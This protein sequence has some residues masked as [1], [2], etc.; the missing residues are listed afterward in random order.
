MNLLTKF[1]LLYRSSGNRTCALNVYIP[2]FLLPLLLYFATRSFPIAIFIVFFIIPAFLSH[3]KLFYAF[4]LTETNFFFN[5]SIISLLYI[6][7]CFEFLVVPLMIISPS[8]SIIFYVLFTS[9]VLFVQKIKKNAPRSAS[10]V[11][12]TYCKNNKEYEKVYSPKQEATPLYLET[13][14]DEIA[15]CNFCYTTA[16]QRNV[17]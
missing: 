9:I 14:Q 7:M 11:N 2:L 1:R 4:G 6:F 13:T 3:M 15:V 12:C 5:W 10:R 17:W 16:F 8:E